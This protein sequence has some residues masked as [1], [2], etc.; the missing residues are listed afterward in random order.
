MKLPAGTRDMLLNLSVLH[1]WKK[2]LI[3]LLEALRLHLQF[4]QSRQIRKE[5]LAQR[6]IVANDKEIFHLGTDARHTAQLGVLAAI[7]HGAASA[8]ALAAG[9]CVDSWRGEKML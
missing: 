9:I 1:E 6:Q 7:K 4:L 2:L 3:D 8:L 5:I